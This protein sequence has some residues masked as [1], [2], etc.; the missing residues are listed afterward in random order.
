MPEEAV[1]SGVYSH[2]LDLLSDPIFPAV[3]AFKCLSRLLPGDVSLVL[4]TVTD[5]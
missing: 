2:R 3:V 1:T 5:T 4:V